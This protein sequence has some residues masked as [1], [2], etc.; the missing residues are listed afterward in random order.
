MFYNHKSNFAQSLKF[1]MSRWSVKKRKIAD[2]ENKKSPRT[3]TKVILLS[4]WFAHLVLTM[5]FVILFFVSFPPFPLHTN[6]CDF[7]YSKMF[8]TIYSSGFT[9]LPNLNL[10]ARLF[11]FYFSASLSMLEVLFSQTDLLICPFVIR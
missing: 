3:G 2:P 11:T 7:S 4:A 5:Q 10:L 8:L 9:C 1:R 6:N